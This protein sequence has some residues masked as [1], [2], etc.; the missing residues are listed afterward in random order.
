MSQHGERFGVAVFVG[1]FR[2][3]GFAPV[4]RLHIE[5]VAQ[6]RGNPLLLTQVRQPIPRKNAFD[7]DDEVVAVG[8]NDPEKRLGRGRQIFMHEFRA[9][10]S[11]DTDVHRLGV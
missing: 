4:N 5:G 6:D 2:K 11:E 7:S 8:S 9:V 3:M 10:L 1:Q